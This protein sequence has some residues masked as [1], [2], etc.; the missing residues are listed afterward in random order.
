R[1]GLRA[2]YFPA[3]PVAGPSWWQGD[4]ANEVLDLTGFGPLGDLPELGDSAFPHVRS[5]ILSGSGLS[6]VQV[7]EFLSGFAQL[8][9]LNLSTNQLTGLPQAIDA[10]GELSEL[11][12]SFNQIRITASAQAQLNRLP[13]LKT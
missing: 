7:N 4:A 6:T 3:E 11:N 8:R 10:L 1:K 13:H 12:L 9:S 2:R 5:L